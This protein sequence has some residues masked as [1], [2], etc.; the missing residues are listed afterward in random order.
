[1]NKQEFELAQLLIDKLSDKK[2]NLEGFKDT[3]AIKLLEAI[4]RKGK[5][6][7]PPKKP[8][9]P[10]KSLMQALKASLKEKK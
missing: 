8:A 4:K 3:F 9:I 6:I 7:P 1:M 5:V 2:F 10:Q